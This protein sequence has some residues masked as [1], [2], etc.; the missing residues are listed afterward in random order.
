[1]IESASASGL[2]LKLGSQPRRLQIQV[3]T[4]SLIETYNPRAVL[5]ASL[6]GS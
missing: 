5:L 3:A 6:L 2:Q 4:S 1:M